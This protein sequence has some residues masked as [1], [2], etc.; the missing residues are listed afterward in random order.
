MNPASDSVE[1]ALSARR[2]YMQ[3]IH[4]EYEGSIELELTDEYGMILQGSD[5]D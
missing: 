5:N 2:H 1:Y 4:D 3:F